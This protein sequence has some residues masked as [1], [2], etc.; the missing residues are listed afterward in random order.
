MKIL[1]GITEI[2]LP[3]SELSCSLIMG[4]EGE[5]INFPVTKKSFIPFFLILYTSF[6]LAKTS[7]ASYICC[8]LFFVLG[9]GF[10]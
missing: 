1:Q 7:L 6:V 3:C 2:L 8:K 5:S 10:F 4:E 9:L